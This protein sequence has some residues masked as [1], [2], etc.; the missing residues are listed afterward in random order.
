MIKL[1]TTEELFEAAVHF[2]HSVGKLHPKMKPY[3]HSV[4]NNVHL[5]DL[6]KTKECLKKALDFVK[7]VAAKDGKILFVGTKPTAQAAIKK[8]AEEVGMPYVI[9]RWLG[10]TMT[11]FS[12][13][14]SLIKKLKKMEEEKASGGWE[15]YTKK[16][17]LNLDREMER[18][19]LFVGGI[20][21]LDK[22]PEAIYIVDL[23]EEKTAVREARKAKIKSIG[24]V[25]VNCDPTE[26]DF[27]IPA[28]DD[29]VKSVDLI[30]KLI[31]EAIRAGKSK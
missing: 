22:F 19:N 26:V 10:G 3:I 23:R 1:P 15:K 29:A 28:N 6:E 4:K 2:G 11:N 30:T 27:P 17:R 18:L 13:I 24:L 12:T 31:A 20:R 9:E 21:N 16:E 8:Y 7:E 5:L 25:D 14:S